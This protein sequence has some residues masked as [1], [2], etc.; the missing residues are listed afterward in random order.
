[1]NCS[2]QW[3]GTPSSNTGTAASTYAEHAKKNMVGRGGQGQVQGRYDQQQQQWNQVKVDQVI[4]RRNWCFDLSDPL[5][6]FQKA[7]LLLFELL[8]LF[9]DL[10]IR[11]KDSGN[12]PLN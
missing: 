8:A 12:F 10:F 3:P 6:S 2:L 7:S 11:S 5:F 9:Q 4:W 1:M